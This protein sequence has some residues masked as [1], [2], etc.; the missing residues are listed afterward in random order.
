MRTIVYVDGFNLYFGV[1]KGTPYKW[2]DLQKLFETVLPQNDILQIRYF[3]A[4]V[5]ARP[6]NPAVHVRQDAYLRAIKA[7]CPKVSIHYGHYLRHEVRMENAVPPPPTVRVWKNEEKGSDVN[8][9]V[10]LLNDAWL[11]AYDCGVVVSND[12]DLC[13]AIDLAK[14][15]GKRIGL[16]PPLGR[17][18]KMSGALGPRM[19]FIRRLSTGSLAGSQLPN[20]I[21]GTT[22]QK[23][24]TW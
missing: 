7:M 5:Q 12:S 19:T 9:A 18:R 23:P 17:D 24:A 3:T 22:I 10:H 6:N 20:Q 11:N 1:L 16:I 2:L 15:R 21:P 13:M 4:K 14:T 8:L